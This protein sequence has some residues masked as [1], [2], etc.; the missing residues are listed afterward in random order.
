MHV[1]L[2]TYIHKHFSMLLE[3]FI[4]RGREIVIAQNGGPRAARA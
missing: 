3:N 1:H 2:H 4:K